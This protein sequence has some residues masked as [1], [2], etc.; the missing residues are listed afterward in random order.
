MSNRSTPAADRRAAS[1]ALYRPRRID[2]LDR[3]LLIDDT[4]EDIT[5][6]VTLL[7][8]SAQRRRE[9]KS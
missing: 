3:Y 8:T 7:C 2:D 5:Q 6:F 9:V 1:A 4:E